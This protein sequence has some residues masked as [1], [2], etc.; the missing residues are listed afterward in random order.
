MGKLTY[1][2]SGVNIEAG[3][4]SVKDIKKLAESTKIDGVLGKI[5]HFGAL[6]QPN[7]KGLKEPILVS[8]TD[9]VGTKLKLAF[10][11]GIHNTVGIDLVAMSVND[12]ICCGAKP[13]F[14][15]DYIAIQKL[16]PKLVK[17]IVEG[18]TEG[19]KQA[20]CALIGG[21]TAELTDMYAKGEYDLAGFAVGIVDKEKI[22]DGSKIKIGDKI[23]A[24]A[25]SGLHS[26]G[27]TL[28][29]KALDKP[30]Y[31]EMLTPTKIYA[32]EINNL[33]E[34]NIEIHGIANI[35]GGGLPLKLGR[36]IPDGLQANIDKKSWKLPA[37]FKTIQEK[38]NIDEQEMFHTF[39]MGIGL[40]IIVP[41]KEV[42]KIKNG[43]VIGDIVKGNKKVSL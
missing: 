2:A 25:S 17:Q 19:C 36:I 39:N 42:S 38:G 14:F 41:E 23:I 43:F 3:E 30:F 22:I 6:F 40:T 10:I 29:R 18:I 5:G 7:L 9:G 33:T 15:L 20:G 27:Y 13:L 12:L 35:T 1:E 28:A 26:N 32:K 21:E 24:L 37:I 4:A 8:S 16:E 11:T 34:K 31:K